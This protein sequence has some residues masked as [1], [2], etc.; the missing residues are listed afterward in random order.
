MQ[1]REIE[2]NILRN[3]ERISSQKNLAQEIGFSVGKVNYVLKKLVEKGFV[4]AERFLNSNN[5]LQYKYLLTEKGFK[6]KVALTE[7]FIE[8]KKEEYDQLQEEMQLYKKGL[9]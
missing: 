8:I 4:K 3:V 5:K 2:L 1:N 9:A 6:E 7:K